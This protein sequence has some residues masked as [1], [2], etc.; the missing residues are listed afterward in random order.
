MYL[1]IGYTPKFGPA[2]IKLFGIYGDKEN[3]KERILTDDVCGKDSYTMS[4]PT[5]SICGNNCIAWI[6]ER[7]Y[8]DYNGYLIN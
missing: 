4:T 2:H 6:I 3:A 5:K 1:V 7:P 8:G